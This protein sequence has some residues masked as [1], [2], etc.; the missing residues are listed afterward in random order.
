MGISI[1]T[2]PDL[3]DKK[4]IKKLRKLGITMVELGVQTVFDKIL[5]KCKRGHKVKE[6]IQATKLLKDAG[7]KVMYQMMPNLPGSNPE[8]DFEAFKIIFKNQEFKPDWLK[9]Y[10]CLVCKGTKLY[11]LWREGKYK[12][13]SDKVLTNL[14]MKVKQ[15]IPYWIRVARIFRDI[16]ATLIEA[17][18]KISNLREVVL[19][20]LRRQNKRCHCIRCREVKE[21]YNPGEKIYFFREDYNASDGREIFLSFENEKRSKLLSFLRLRIPSSIFQ[22]RNHFISP[23]QNASI[24]REIHTYGELVQIAKKEMAPQHRGLG[25]RLVAAAERISKQEFDLPKIAVISGVGVRD[26]WRKLGYRL[27]ESY[28]I[29]RLT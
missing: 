11:Q 26:Y 9:I 25:K 29:K 15:N 2:R 17:G 6:T 23:L 8:R 24:I 1:E 14:L 3:I 18:S 16:P 21:N 28:M 19:E 12:S 20:K 10:P 7:F 22:K 27:K 4:E 5:E 13:Y